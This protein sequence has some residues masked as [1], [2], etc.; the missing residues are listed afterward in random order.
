MLLTTP[1]RVAAKIVPPGAIARRNAP[2]TPFDGRQLSPLSVL[3]KMTSPRVRAYNV[4]GAEGSMSSVRIPGDAAGS[5]VS[6]AV[7]R[8]AKAL[9]PAA[10]SMSANVERN[11]TTGLQ[12]IS[13]GL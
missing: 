12:H 8:A 5:P 7:Q 2:T 9:P 11:V 4:E 10:T 6:M 3:L 1:W 13:R